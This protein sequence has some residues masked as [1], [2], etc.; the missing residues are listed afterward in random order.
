[1]KKYIIATL[2]FFNFSQQTINA[3][4]NPNAQLPAKLKTTATLKMPTG[5]IGQANAVNAT[6]ITV[7]VDTTIRVAPTYAYLAIDFAQV[8]GTN[9]IDILNGTHLFWIFDKTGKEIKLPLKVLSSVKAAM[10]GNGPVELKVRVP[11]RLKTDKNLYTIHYR[12]E[13]KDKSRNIDVLTTK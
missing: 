1:M 11:F 4:T 6:G 3:Q 10:E 8:T 7:V 5:V 2:A 12:W 9:N 13:S